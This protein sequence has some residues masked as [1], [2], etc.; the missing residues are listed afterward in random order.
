MTLSCSESAQPG[1]PVSVVDWVPWGS[2]PKK[3]WFKACG[4]P[5]ILIANEL[6][7]AAG[8]WVALE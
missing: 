3:I 6:L 2:C 8:S 7:G 4:G 5:E 1:V